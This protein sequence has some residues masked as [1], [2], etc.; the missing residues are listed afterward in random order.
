MSEVLHS[1]EEQTLAEQLDALG[2]DLQ[3]GAGDTF[4]AARRAGADT[5][6]TLNPGRLLAVVQ[7]REAQLVALESGERGQERTADDPS[8]GFGSEG[9]PSDL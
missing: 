8:T 4:I 7:Q 2:W 6:Q 1:V 5:Q 3:K 9:A